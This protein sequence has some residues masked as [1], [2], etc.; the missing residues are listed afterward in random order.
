MGINVLIGIVAAIMVVGGGTYVAMNP[1]VITSI[2]G[3]AVEDQ[4]ISPE[5]DMDSDSASVGSTFAELVALG[6]SVECTF[7]YDDG[8]GNAS[9]GT[10][11]MTGG[12]AEMRGDFVV[13]SPMA[14][15]AH[16]I[17]TGGYNYIWGPDMPQGIK[18]KVTNETELMAGSQDSGIDENTQFACQAWNVDN[19]QFA[20]P[21]G[22]DFMEITASV[23]ADASVSAPGGSVNASGSAS[24]KAQQ[25]AGCT[26]LS[27][28]A[29]D[30][31][32]AALA[33]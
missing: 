24:V 32:L 11:Y 17:R 22:V 29:K 23:N 26:M 19:G 25:C 1:E 8:T 33:C 9:S 4:M 16:M 14:T 27:G 5:N 7:T 30:Q 13:T 20:I 2:T 10:V 28:S 6:Q 21:V 31:C 18:T 3:G 12:A 15:E